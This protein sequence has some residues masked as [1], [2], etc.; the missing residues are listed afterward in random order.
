MFT[1]EQEIISEINSD[2]EYSLDQL[3]YDEYPDF[4]ITSA[5]RYEMKEGKRLDRMIILQRSTGKLFELRPIEVDYY[6]LSEEE[7][8]QVET[9]VEN[10]NTSDALPKISVRTKW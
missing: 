3:G 4:R 10:W 9:S 8:E 2:M 7:R 6:N 5:V 1:D